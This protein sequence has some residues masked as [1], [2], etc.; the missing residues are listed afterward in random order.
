[1]DER[2]CGICY[3][4]C[5]HDDIIWLICAHIFCINCI[6]RSLR[7]KNECPICRTINDEESM[8][9]HIK[10]LSLKEYQNENINNHNN[11]ILTFGKYKDKTFLWV[12]ENNIYYCLWCIDN[13]KENTNIN[14]Q[15]ERF[16]DY[17]KQKRKKQ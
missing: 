2:L 1:M 12:Y 4:K 13:Y 7:I 10:D 9:K 8:L 6:N 16:V 3:E 14:T 15:F 11:E 17:I 5:N